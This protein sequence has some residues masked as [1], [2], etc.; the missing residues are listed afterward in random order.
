[1]EPKERLRKARRMLA[2]Q[3]ARERLAAWS[4]SDLET[5]D[6]LMRERRADLDRFLDAGTALGSAFSA[7]TLRR[8]QGLAEAQAALE[9]EKELC[10]ARRREERLRL[11][12]AELIV[13]RLARESERIDELRRL[14]H[15]IE[16][17][18]QRSQVRPE[19][20]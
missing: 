11:R 8:L 19:Q 2:V 1:M 14:D 10:V 18:Q 4:V 15:V 3:A 12:C 6:A 13:D 20:G 16:A 7:S 9:A 5:Q 17:A